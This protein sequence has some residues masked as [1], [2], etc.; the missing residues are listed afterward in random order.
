[1]HLWNPCLE[2]PAS[3]EPYPSPSQWRACGWWSKSS[4]AWND[5]AGMQQLHVCLVSNSGNVFAGHPDPC[6]I[7]STFG[8]QYFAFLIFGH[9]HTVQGSQGVSI[10]ILVIHGDVL[11]WRGSDCTQEWGGTRTPGRS[12]GT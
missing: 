5:L 4:A 10:Q 3:L 8:W 6:L 2:H 11:G 12:D 7:Y 1:L 9:L